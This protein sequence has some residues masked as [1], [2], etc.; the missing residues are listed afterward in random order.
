MK[1]S[2]VEVGEVFS[3]GDGNEEYDVEVIATLNVDN[4]EYVAVA[5]VD[6]LEEG[7]EEDIEIF[8][9]KVDEEGDFEEIESDDEFEAV[10]K[11]FDKMIDD[12]EG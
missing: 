11:A 8:F 3:I 1:M 7:V 2:K 12:F 5:Y 10:S 4:N 9:L 6:N